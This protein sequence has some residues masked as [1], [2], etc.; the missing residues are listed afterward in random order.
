MSKLRVE[1]VS[2]KLASRIKT[3]Y[4]TFD[5]GCESYQE[6]KKAHEAQLFLHQTRPTIMS[7]AKNPTKRVWIPKYI[8]TLIESELDKENPSNTKLV[9]HMTELAQTVGC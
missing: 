3:L 7:K 5:I 9:K 4:N 8:L 1:N 2:E 6:A